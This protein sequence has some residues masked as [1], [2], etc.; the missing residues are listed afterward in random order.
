MLKPKT[1]NKKNGNVKVIK[2]DNLKMKVKGRHLTNKNI[3]KYKNKLKI[4]VV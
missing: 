2:I 4:T 3:I 1:L